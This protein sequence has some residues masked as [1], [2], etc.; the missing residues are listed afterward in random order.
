MNR[1]LNRLNHNKKSNNH[2]RVSEKT[3][4]KK[5]GA[6]QVAGSGSISGYKSDGIL[7]NFRIENKATK[8]KSYSIKYEVLFKILREALDSGRYPA[9]ITSFVDSEGNSKEFGDWITLPLSAF[10]TLMEFDD[11]I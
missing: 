3:N 2:G 4:M 5:I 7:P 8:N 9:L 10:K 1:Y 11:K 6:Q